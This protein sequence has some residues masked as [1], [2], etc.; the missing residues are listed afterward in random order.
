[1]YMWSDEWV[2]EDGVAEEMA[3]CVGVPAS[4][5]IVPFIYKDLFRRLM[6]TCR[7]V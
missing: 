3:E 2:A 1:M 6:V 4:T 5:Y 7:V